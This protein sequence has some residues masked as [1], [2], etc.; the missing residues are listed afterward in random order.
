MR[1][2]AKHSYFKRIAGVVRNF[3]NIEKTIASRHQRYMCY[4][5]TCSTDFLCKDPAYGP[6]KFMYCW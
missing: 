4:K 6:G 5:M 2:E 1:F 3:K